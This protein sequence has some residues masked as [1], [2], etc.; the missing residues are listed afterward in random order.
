MCGRFA[1]KTDRVGQQDSLFVRQNQAA[2]R[3]IERRE[4]SVLRENARAGEQI[5][6]GRFAGVGVADDGGHR[7][8]MPLSALALHRAMFAHLIEVALQS[9]NPF[10]DAAAIDFELCFARAPRPDAAGLAGK[11][12][13]HSR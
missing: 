12:R 7:P 10:L 3:R 11:V 1:Q 6:Q 8:L 5:E 2:G 4:E 13:P 9:R